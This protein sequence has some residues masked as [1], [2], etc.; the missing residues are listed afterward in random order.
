VATALTPAQFAAAYNLTPGSVSTTTAPAQTFATHTTG[1][2][3]RWDQIAW[4]FY[5][6]PTLIA[7]IILANPT[8]PIVS[9]LPQ[10][11]TVYVPLIAPPSAPANALPWLP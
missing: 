1:P 3:D 6:D 11:L 5:G 9:V 2:A 8:I 7:G 10:G 4:Q